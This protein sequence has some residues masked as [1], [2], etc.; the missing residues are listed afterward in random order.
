MG[1]RRLFWR[2]VDKVEALINQGE[3]SAGSRLPP[4]RELADMFDVSR[5]TIREAII[6]LEVRGR[7]EVKTGSGV[8]VIEQ[9]ET[10]VKT[11]EISAFELT[12]ARALIE[13]EIAALAAQSITD[14][15]LAQLKQTL[16]AMEKG[17]YVE[18]AD[19]EFH[20]IIARATRNKALEYAV[21][22]LW[23][24]RLNNS[25]IVADYGSVCK[26]NNDCVMDE[27]TAIY[28]A[29]Q[30]H[31][32]SAARTAMHKHFNRLINAL[33]D[34][35]EARALEE[36]KRKNDEKRGLYSLDGLVKSASKTH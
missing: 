8:Y 19:R 11:K 2:I 28:N 31:D 20:E 4:E 16:I 15:E 13:G 21:A 25:Q 18:Q 35:V 1:N 5:P 23:D 9:Q 12:Q 29:L 33:F 32:A 17:L 10:S 36:I 26:N 3:F 14:E 24:L 30:T 27:H 7:V 34:A 6:A 22:N